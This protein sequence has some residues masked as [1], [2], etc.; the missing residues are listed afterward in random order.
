ML[1]TGQRLISRR[2]VAGVVVLILV[3]LASFAAMAVAL[4]GAG[5]VVGVAGL[6]FLGLH[7]IAALRAFVLPRRRRELPV[8]EAGRTII[9]APGSLVWPLVAAWA[10]V[11]ILAAAFVVQAIV[12]VDSIESPGAA[13][14]VVI[15]TVFG[16]PDWF[17]LVTGRLHR[18]RVVLGPEDLSYRGYRTAIEVPW[19][20]VRGASIQV[21]GRTRGE[22][23]QRQTAGVLINLK[24]TRPD[25]VIPA[26]AFDVPA[27]QI[28]EEIQK[29]L[30]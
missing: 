7:L 21:G 11:P 6:V 30:R 15:A 26:A 29:R 17:R 24:G 8:D 25:P 13:F 14:A 5:R 4:D 12:D 2:W 1:T 10:A 18:W 3:G 27:E 23:K 28:V 22:T 19:S 9:E 20:R 16:L